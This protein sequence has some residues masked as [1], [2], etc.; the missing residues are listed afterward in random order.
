MIDH[1]MSTT[2]VTKR[3]A[4]TL[5]L[6][7]TAALAMLPATVLAQEESPS[8]AAES[9]APSAQSTLPPPELATPQGEGAARLLEALPHELAGVPFDPDNVTLLSGDQVAGGND[10]V[11]AQY[12]AVEEATGVAVADMVLLTSYVET[13]AGDLVVLGG[14]LVPGADASVA[15]D[16]ILDVMTETDG[17]TVEEA[18]IADLPVTVVVEDGLAGSTTYVYP[19]GD[20]LW[21]VLGPEEAAAEAFTH[22]SGT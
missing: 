14:L 17:A 13:E 2:H 6:A 11:M 4:L 9:A 16:V 8:P 21:L 19:S 3:R 18:E 5:T 20:I 22:V 12:R 15:R 10:S 1:R 7:L